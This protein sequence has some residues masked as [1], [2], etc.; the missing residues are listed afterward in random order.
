MME[1][2]RQN[3]GSVVKSPVHML[4]DSPKGKSSWNKMCA[5]MN[6][7]LLHSGFFELCLKPY[8]IICNVGKSVHI[9]RS[10]TVMTS[11]QKW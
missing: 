3:I 5:G 11:F 8:S 6:S 1:N 9:Q 4:W 7:K 2:Y 10:K